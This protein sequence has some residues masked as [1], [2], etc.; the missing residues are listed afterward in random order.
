MAVNIDKDACR[1]PV[2][3]T[4]QAPV[5]FGGSFVY[6]RRKQS[7]FWLSDAAAYQHPAVYK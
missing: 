4:V 7:L 3:K 6:H 2:P 5:Q 1:F